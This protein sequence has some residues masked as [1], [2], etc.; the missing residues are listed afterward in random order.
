M[1]KTL[2]M[3][4][5]EEELKM[6]LPTWIR[7]KCRAG[8][9]QRAMADHLGLPVSTLNRWVRRCGYSVFQVAQAAWQDDAVP[10]VRLE[11]ARD[12][13]APIRRIHSA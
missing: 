12:R 7:L 13:R 11:R 8:W 9:T 5:I 4:V 6:D 10:V 3:E 1:H 2:L